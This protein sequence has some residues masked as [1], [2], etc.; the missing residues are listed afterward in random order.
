MT[1]MNKKAVSVMIGY[2][3]LISAAVVMGAIVYQWLRTYMPSEGLACPEDVSVFLKESSCSIDQLNLTLKNNG[4]FDIAGYFIHVTNESWQELADIDISPNILSGGIGAGGA[5][6]FVAGSDNP[7]KPGDEKKSN[8]NLTDSGF[9]Q[10]YLIEIIP[11]RFQ[12]IENKLRFVSCGGAKIKEKVDCDLG[13]IDTDGGN[14]KEVKGTCTDYTG[15]GGTDYCEG[16][17][18]N[19]N[20]QKEWYCLD[21]LCVKDTTGCPSV[22]YLCQEGECVLP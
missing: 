11:V 15:G 17:E 2:I 10:I 8:F 1:K 16:G 20:A 21:D 3:L 14:N 7:M 6:I 12:E 18:E 4:K 5:V 9:E 19:S 22:D 13:C